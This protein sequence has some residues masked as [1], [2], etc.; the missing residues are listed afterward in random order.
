MGQNEVRLA[1]NRERYAAIAL[2]SKSNLRLIISH[3]VIVCCVIVITLLI[4]TSGFRES[5]PDGSNKRLRMIRVKRVVG[6]VLRLDILWLLLISNDDYQH[7]YN[8][9][10]SVQQ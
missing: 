9:L 5:S 7:I 10:L 4:G 8:P 6:R 3:V 1:R 2:A